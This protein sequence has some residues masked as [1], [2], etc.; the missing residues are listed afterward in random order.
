MA[1]APLL[2]A[3]VRALRRREHMT[4]VDLAERLGVSASYLNLIENNRRPL[5]APLLIRLAQIFQLDLQNFASEE[6]VRLTADLHE[7]FGDPIFESHGLT[8]ADLRELVASS[9]N[10]ARAVLTLYRTYATTRESLDTLGERLAG[11]GFV[12]VDNSRLPSEEVSDLIQRRMNHFPELEEGAEA[13]WREAELDAD[14]V[15]RGLVRYLHATRGIEV[16]IVRVADERQAMRRYDPERRVLSISEVL[17]PR[18]RRFQLAHQL[19]LLTQSA[20]IDRIL[21]DENLTTPESRALARVALANYFAAAILMPYQPFLEAARAERYDIELLA[22]RFGTSFEQVCHRLTTLRRPGAEGVPMHMVRI[23][24]AGNISKRFSGSGI[25]FARFSG[26]CPRWN[27]HAAL[28]T[29]GMI[30]I[31]L[32]QMPDGAVYFC[33]A[34]T[35]RSDR[36]GYHVPHTVQS[37]GMGCDVRYARELVYADG[38]DLDNIG[39]AVPVGVTCRTCERLDCAQRALPALQH[40]LRLDENRRGV[41]FYASVDK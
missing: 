41:S 1:D 31:Q 18:S 39:A 5:T 22:H 40:P 26:A 27:V 15:Y 9:P 37:I 36:G 38:I 16:R 28:M 7:A 30:R 34:R 35:V 14:D 19:G 24:I 12:A 33:I 29:P 17:P 32:S 23:D 6:D 25:R 4:Q 20:A 10:V 11:D 8:N 3:K 2:G 21:R 13:L